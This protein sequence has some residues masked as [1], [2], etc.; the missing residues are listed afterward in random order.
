MGPL[1][2]FCTRAGQMDE[3]QNCKTAVA[4]P[5]QVR[6]EAETKRRHSDDYVSRKTEQ[7]PNPNDANPQINVGKTNQRRRERS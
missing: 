2:R 7:A 1:C 5:L 4:Q 3:K 6:E